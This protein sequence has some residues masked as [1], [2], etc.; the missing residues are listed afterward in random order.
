ME[1]ADSW[2]EWKFFQTLYHLTLDVLRGRKIFSAHRAFATFFFRVLCNIWHYIC[3]NWAY[4]SEVTQRYVIERRLK[5]WEFSGF[6]YKTYGNCVLK[7]NFIL[8]HTPEFK[9]QVQTLGT[10]DGSVMSSRNRHFMQSLLMHWT[11]VPDT[12]MLRPLNF[13]FFDL[14][15]CLCF[16]FR[17]FFVPHFVVRGLLSTDGCRI[18]QKKQQHTHTNEVDRIQICVLYY[19]HNLKFISIFIII[20]KIFQSAT[21]PNCVWWHKSTI[22]TFLNVH[23]IYKTYCR[24]I[25]LSKSCFVGP[26]V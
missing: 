16:I 1:L 26:T 22:I 3:K 24:P 20:C 11:Q 21:L 15:L 9:S 4:C 17:L 14:P 10:W 19:I 18:V 6:V 23:M 13:C 5:I 7:I 12:S 25:G 8:T 2:T